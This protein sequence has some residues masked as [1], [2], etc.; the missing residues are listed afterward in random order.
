MGSVVAA[1]A[2]YISIKEAAMRIGCDHH[3]VRNLMKQKRL[4]IHHTEPVN[5][6]VSKVFLTKKSVKLYMEDRRQRYAI[7]IRVTQHEGRQVRSLLDSLRVLP[8][9]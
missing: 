3:Y 7:K 2:D 8:D 1:K 5:S 9:W 6:G 4:E